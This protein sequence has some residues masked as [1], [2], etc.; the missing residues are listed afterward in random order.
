MA[1]TATPRLLDISMGQV[2]QMTLQVD[3]VVMT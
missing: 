3:M 2:A 1:I